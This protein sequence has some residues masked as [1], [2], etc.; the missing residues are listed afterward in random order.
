M[1]PYCNTFCDLFSLYKGLSG[2]N[3]LDE[4][5]LQWLTLVSLKQI[6]NM[7]WRTKNYRRTK[8]KQVF[9]DS[10]HASAPPHLFLFPFLKSSKS[11]VIHFSKQKVCYCSTTA[12]S[13]LKMQSF[14]NKYLW[15]DLK[16]EMSI[17]LRDAAE[18]YN[19]KSSYYNSTTKQ[20]KFKATRRSLNGSLRLSKADRFSPN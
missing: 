2:N 3:I 1:T 18:E 6:L 9:W 16:L 10:R 17:V 14:K 5:L 7:L 12:F 13:W 20:Q 15:R 19:S 8:N 11:A 4:E